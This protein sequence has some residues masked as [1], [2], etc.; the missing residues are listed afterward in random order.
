[1][2]VVVATMVATSTS[3][4]TSASAATAYCFRVFRVFVFGVF[5]SYGLFSV[6]WSI[7]FIIFFI[8]SISSIGSILRC[9]VVRRILFL[10]FITSLSCIS[11]WA[12]ASSI[13]G[14]IGCSVTSL[15][16][17]SLH[18]GD[19]ISRVRSLA[20]FLWRWQCSNIEKQE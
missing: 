9:F 18:M 19:Q 17:I 15:V 16:L 8:L 4:S 2:A 10:C 13:S 12:I 20:P 14:I 6:S 11:L 7:G 3:G 5:G 1:M